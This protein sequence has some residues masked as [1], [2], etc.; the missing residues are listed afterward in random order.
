MIRN[1][2]N[3]SEEIASAMTSRTISSNAY[4]FMKKMLEQE[5]DYF[6]TSI[7]TL[8]EMKDSFIDV[9][10]LLYNNK[11][12]NWWYKVNINDLKT[13]IVLSTEVEPRFNTLSIMKHL[14]LLE[15][16]LY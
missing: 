1:E 5:R 9:F 3:L 6:L 14:G 12:E 15:G 8:E 11:K 2:L 10:K 7:S 16:Y 13:A 4:E